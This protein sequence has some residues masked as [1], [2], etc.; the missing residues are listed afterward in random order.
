MRVKKILNIQAQ[1]TS[2]GGVGTVPHSRLGSSSSPAPL[3]V[4]IQSGSARLAHV[5]QVKHTDKSTPM[6]ALI[7]NDI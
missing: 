4:H 6:P 2:A 3:S 1:W 5:V 7:T